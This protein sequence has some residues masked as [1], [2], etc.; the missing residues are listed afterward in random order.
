MFI[1]TPPVV[2]IV[3]DSSNG[4]FPQPAMQVIVAGTPTSAL[5]A[6]PF[7]WP[8]IVGWSNGAKQEKQEMNPNC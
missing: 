2:V 3:Q 1:A 4:G 5:M 6:E 7:K 8:R